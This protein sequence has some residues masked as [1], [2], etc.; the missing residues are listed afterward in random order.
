MEVVGSKDHYLV[1]KSGK[2][3][4]EYD[5][6]T[7]NIS[8]HDDLSLGTIIQN[9]SSA[10]YFTLTE[11]L[12]DANIS[13]HLCGNYYFIPEEAV[14]CAVNI[15]KKEIEIFDDEEDESDN[16]CSKNE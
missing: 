10:E 5:C 6:H 11:V 2:Q 16:G 1:R 4:V 14:I 7:V 15:S 3:Q 8:T 9:F 12:F 13:Y